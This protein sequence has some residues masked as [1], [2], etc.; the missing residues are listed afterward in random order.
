M[1]RGGTI[2]KD[3]VRKYVLRK[4]TH[5]S[6]T[7]YESTPHGWRLL[8]IDLMDYLATQPKRTAKKGGIGK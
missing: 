3:Y 7:R 4:L 5:S 6:I 1:A 8:A 2:E